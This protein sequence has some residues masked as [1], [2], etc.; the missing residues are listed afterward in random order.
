VS[1]INGIFSLSFFLSVPV[2]FLLEGVIIGFRNFAWGF[3][4]QKNKIWSKTKFGGPPLRWV[5]L[6][7]V[8][9]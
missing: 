4:S 1:P 7:G 8:F 5:D 2:T 3:K 6:L 9:F